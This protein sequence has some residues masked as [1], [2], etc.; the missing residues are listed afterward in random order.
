MVDWGILDGG[1][2]AAT[3]A[4]TAAPAPVDGWGV[5]DGR[6]PRGTT[7]PVVPAQAG[8]P[9]ERPPA[10]VAA[11]VLNAGDTVWAKVERTGA[12]LGAGQRVILFADPADGLYGWRPVRIVDPVRLVAEVIPVPM[13]VPPEDVGEDPAQLYE[14]QGPP[15]V[16]G[17]ARRPG[18]PVGTGPDLRA[19]LDRQMADVEA[20]SQ[21]EQQALRERIGELE[22]ELDR[23]SN[24]RHR[25]L[26]LFG[27]GD[28]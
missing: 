18:F 20:R 10:R 19:M 2:P 14:P 17:V 4:A 3:K 6:P 12:T 7:T 1:V 22:A 27:R 15:S 5:L 16:A 11:S 21:H 9:Q 23:V 24:A 8:P 25:R 13:A 28:A 26:G